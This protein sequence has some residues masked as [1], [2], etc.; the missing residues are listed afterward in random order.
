MIKIMATHI[1]QE[2]VTNDLQKIIEQLD[3]GCTP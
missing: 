2:L 1:L 3:D